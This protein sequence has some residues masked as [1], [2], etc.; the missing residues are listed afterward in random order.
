MWTRSEQVNNTARLPGSA[1]RI[2]SSIAER[3]VETR[4]AGVRVDALHVHGVIEVH[5]IVVVAH[6][7]K[8]VR[9]VEGDN[10]LQPTTEHP[11]AGNTSRVGAQT[12][13]DHSDPRKRRASLS[14]QKVNVL[15]HEMADIR[16][17]IA[18]GQ[19]VY[20]SGAAAPVNDK[21]IKE[22]MVEI[23]VTQQIVYVRI[24]IVVPSVNDYP[25]AVR[26][27]KVTVPKLTD[28]VE[29]NFLWMISTVSR[30][31]Q[32]TNIVRWIKKWLGRHVV[33]VYQV[34]EAI[35]VGYHLPVWFYIIVTQRDVAK[36]RNDMSDDGR[37]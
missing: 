23:G 8:G 10:V 26:R 16:D 2:E 17:A 14:V 1:I 37:Y 34:H 19:V 12:V 24:A 33:N 27:I 15:R 28:I 35:A 18:R 30:E 29:R 13:P 31:K 3:I 5:P 22:S 7:E 21:H 36:I 25:G 11:L 32:Y 20:G 6:R 4:T 9:R